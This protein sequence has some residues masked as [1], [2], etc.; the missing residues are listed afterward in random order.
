[1]SE[2]GFL[3]VL[4]NSSMPGLVKVGKTTRSPT[5]RAAELSGVTGM[6]TPFLVVYDQLFQDCHSAESFVH[7]YLAEKGYRVAE[8]REFFNAPVNLV[9]RAIGLAPGQIDGDLPVSNA[10][11]VTD[12][13][14]LITSDAGDEL[15]G[16]KFEATEQAAPWV[17]LFE[18]AEAHYYGLGDHIEDRTEALRLFRQA[19]TLGST[20]AYGRIG[21]QYMD[22]EGTPKNPAK[23]FEFYKEG[24]RKGRPTCYF[25]MAQM[26]SSENNDESADKCFSLF[27]RNFPTGTPNKL[28]FSE[29]E[30]RAVYLGCVGLVM[31]RIRTGNR[32]RHSVIDAFIVSHK[33]FVLERV[34][35][36]QEM[37][38]R[39][40]SRE[41]SDSYKTAGEYVAAI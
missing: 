21:N 37:A 26:F 13:D 17:A 1:M 22:G 30:A 8:N 15:D 33:Q 32:N 6:A 3:Y 40:G 25:L 38:L 14:E 12:E 19:A 31:D 36:L 11:E 5:E 35:M 18:K 28:T 4:A 2:I 24:A 23:A 27:V 34:K 16:L 9:V 10:P 41:L 7:V 20:E 29:D 39:R